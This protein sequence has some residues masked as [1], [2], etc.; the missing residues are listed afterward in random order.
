MDD[1]IKKFTLM[2]VPVVYLNTP[3][4]YGTWHISFRK[5]VKGCNMGDALMFSMPEDRLEAFKRRTAQMKVKQEQKQ[6]ED[7]NYEGS[8]G[9]KLEESDQGEEEAKARPKR[10]SKGKKA[11]RDRDESPSDRDEPPMDRDGPSLSKPRSTTSKSASM[12]EIDLASEPLKVEPKTDEE[13]LLLSSLGIT[14]TMDEFF[15]ATTVFVNVRTSNAD[16]EKEAFYRQ[17]IWAWMETSLEKGN[18]KW[19]ARSVSPVYDIHAF[20]TKISSLANRATWISYALEFKKIFT[21]PAGSDIFQYHAEVLQQIKMVKAQGETLGLTTTI[22][23]EMEQC[24]LIIAAWQLPQYRKIALEFTMDDKAVTVETLVKEL[25]RQRLLTA[26][27]NQSGTGLAKPSRVH[28]DARVAAASQEKICY[29]FQKGKCHREEC[30]F[31]HVMEKGG[32]EKQQAKKQEKASKTAPSKK[33]QPPKAN[34]DAKKKKGPKPCYRCGSEAHLA[35]ECKFEGKCDYCKKDGHKQS[36]C[37]KKLSDSSPIHAAKAEEVSIRLTCVQE[38]ER[39]PGIW[40]DLPESQPVLPWQDLAVDY[41]RLEISPEAEVTALQLGLVP[42]TPPLRRASAMYDDDIVE[43]SEDEM[44]IPNDAPVTVQMLHAEDFEEVKEDDLTPVYRE[45]ALEVSYREQRFHQRLNKLEHKRKFEREKRVTYLKRRDEIESALTRWWRRRM[46]ELRDYTEENKEMLYGEYENTV[47]SYLTRYGLI[48]RSSIKDKLSA[49]AHSHYENLQLTVEGGGVANVLVTRDRELKQES[50]EHYRWCVDSGANRNLCKDR[51]QARGR[52]VDRQLVIGEAGVGH[53][54]FSEAEGPID[55]SIQGKKSKLL[56]RTIFASR[57]QENILSVGEAVDC[58]Y[59][60]VFDKKGVCLYQD[61][62]VRGAP[63]LT[64]SRSKYN[65]LFYFDLRQET[66]A[67]NK[68]QVLPSSARI[69]PM[70]YVPVLSYECLRKT[71][72][73]RELPDSKCVPPP[74]VLTRLSRTYH[75]CKTE[76][77]LWHPRLAHV[78]PRLALLA[79]P[80][81]KDWP[82]KCFCAS[83]TQ[84]KFHRHS[85]SGSRPAPEY[86]PWLPGEYW[87]CALFGPLPREVHG[88]LLFTL[89]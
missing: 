1:M 26:H 64:G 84:G 57:I 13:R 5:L 41:A 37:R 4:D 58:G 79:K 19:V 3:L 76:F 85:H 12:V 78:N 71:Q 42:P 18:F 70:D 45:R 22:T 80:D 15:S 63:L 72:A 73:D 17:E 68:V 59:T 28:I 34:V 86:E 25:E 75:E 49:A 61:V 51:S 7:N 35:P 82:K 14:S 39:P 77:E 60:L 55:V 20:Y 46:L 40:D 24:L 81:L 30:P 21:M 10:R 56:A 53:S 44:P 6:D 9:L 62:S 66:A 2:K 27:L 69:S 43:A 74:D 36:V 52:D 48:G 16:T 67:V 38:E 32:A 11:S 83:C 29:A 50:Y 89:I 87:C 31:S 88:T 8:A 47:R 33:Q 23:P 54:F 65:R